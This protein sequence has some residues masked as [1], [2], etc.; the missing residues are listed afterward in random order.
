MFSA[1]HAKLSNVA[2]QLQRMGLPMLRSPKC[3]VN[4]ELSAWAINSSDCHD[5]EA[6]L[7]LLVMFAE[8]TKF[9]FLDHIAFRILP[10]IVTH[11]LIGELN[12]GHG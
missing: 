6:E 8:Q 1:F 3:S 5:M 2:Y 9:C 10:Q 4:F 11:G 12:E 7:L